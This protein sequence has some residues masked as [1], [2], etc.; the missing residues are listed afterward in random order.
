MWTKRDP[1]R[2]LK[3]DA[4]VDPADR[5]SARP[6]QG[7]G[8]ERRRPAALVIGA[9]QVLA[10]GGEIFTK[11]PDHRSGGAL[12]R[13]RGNTHELHSAVVIAGNGATD[14]A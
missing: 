5:G 1:R 10:L 4:R 13:L 11:A 12:R 2:L 7:G 9:D 3:A 8:G 14:W 6:R